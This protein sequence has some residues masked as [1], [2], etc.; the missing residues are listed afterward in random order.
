MSTI[1]ILPDILINQIAAGEVIERPAS[2]VK[3]LVEN[4]LDAGASR[5]S[6][7]L[8]RGGQE[9][10]VVQDD[11]CGMDA[12]DLLMAL[13]RHATSKIRASSDLSS[14]RTLGFRGEALPSIASVARLDLPS[15][16]RGAAEGAH[17]CVEG[18]R[19]G[20]A[21]PCGLAPGTRV[22]VRDLFFNLPARRKFL[23]SPSTEL[24]HVIQ[25]LDHYALGHPG[26]AF[27]LVHEGRE[28]LN[29]PPTERS[30]ERFF[31]LFPEFPP[32][33]FR[34][35]FLERYGFSVQGLAG[36]PDRNLGSP[37]YV[38][39]L[40]NG[41]FVRDRLLQSALSQGYRDILP[42]GRHPAV[43]LRIEVPPER[44]DVN[45]HP[46]K[47]ELR[48]LDGSAIF[49]L[50]A[51]AVR[52]AIAPAEPPPEPRADANSP[53]APAPW[54]VSDSGGVFYPGSTLTQP[55]LTL[56]DVSPLRV[57]GQWRSSFILCDSPEGLAI[58]DQHVA[59]ERVRFEEFRRFLDA[60]G[61]R[62]PFLEP[63]L[64]RLSADLAHR[65]AELADLLSAQGFEAEPF[66]EGTVAVRST[67]AFLSPGE[68]ERLLVDFC[69][70][71]GEALKTPRDRWREV[72]ILRSCRGSVMLHDP[73]PVEA[74]QRLL[75]RLHA[76]RAPL[77]CP[78]GRPI[79]F[80]LREAEILSKF[81][82]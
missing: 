36:R 79:V 9:E 76:L 8:A 40:V 51:R 31:A 16:P 54:R 18:G 81:D 52:T 67:P 30:E 28:I 68:A 38:F 6:V 32:G 56:P 53:E 82:R 71:A 50:V 45:V 4:A 22:V 37:R 49:D 60:P 17:V 48:F 5:I 64:Y 15:R 47:R 61:P 80:T 59:H 44:V 11:G 46:A 3:E 10:I 57:L 27:R 62:Q 72:L 69:R 41:R 19:F 2:V 23:K 7:E 20:D 55:P 1:H 39:T 74:M 65:A 43:L 70:E 26:A 12:D 14:I 58:V 77:T 34:P 33:D 42:R 63:R 78:H 24:S 35:V 66:G 25:I 29:L 73:L 21:K 75:D 13:E